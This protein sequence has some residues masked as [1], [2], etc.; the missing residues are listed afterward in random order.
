MVPPQPKIVTYAGDEPDDITVIQV[1]RGFFR[2]AA[3]SLKERPI[4]GHGELGEPLS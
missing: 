4:Y 3:D 2:R 1:L